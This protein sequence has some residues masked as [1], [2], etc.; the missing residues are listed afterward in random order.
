MHI[1][2]QLY[3]RWLSSLGLKIAKENRHCNVNVRKIISV[4][5]W[6]FT[7]RLEFQRWNFPR[8]IVRFSLS[9]VYLPVN[10]YSTHDTHLK[11]REFDHYSVT[12][13]KQMSRHTTQVSLNLWFKFFLGNPLGQKIIYIQMILGDTYTVYTEWFFSSYLPRI[14]D[15]YI[16]Y[17]D[18][19]Q[20]L[21]LA[22]ALYQPVSRSWH[23]TSSSRGV[24]GVFFG[25]FRVGYSIQ[26]SKWA[27][28]TSGLKADLAYA[29]KDTVW[30]SPIV[31]L[32]VGFFIA[33]PC[34]LF[35]CLCLLL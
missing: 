1:R 14:L 28:S 8:N 16:Q 10:R 11:S 31:D 35:L 24:L 32:P 9:H 18:A 4:K 23:Q 7:Q 5:C 17:D 2:C 13:F 33:F 19:M 27:W 15:Q 20:D 6:S 29:W 12:T 22:L 25:S 21:V 30:S 34:S 3:Q 26:I